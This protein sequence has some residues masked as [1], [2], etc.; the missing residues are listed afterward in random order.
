MINA[1]NYVFFLQFFNCLSNQ[2]F[3]IVLC[4]AHKLLGPQGLEVGLHLAEHEFDGI[5]FRGVRNVVHEVE[6]LLS[7]CFLGPLRCVRGQIVHE[8]TNLVLS[9]SGPK[10]CDVLYK[11]VYVHRLLEDLI[12]IGPLLL[13]Y[14]SK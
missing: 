7:H 12:V 3:V 4:Q 14:T 11:F 2:R 9:R 13:R 5:I 6:A 8:Q 1:L 10:N